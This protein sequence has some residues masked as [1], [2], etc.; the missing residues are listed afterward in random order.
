MSDRDGVKDL[1][2]DQLRKTGLTRET[3]W[4]ILGCIRTPMEEAITPDE[5][6]ANKRQSGVRV[7][8]LPEPDF[9]EAM[10]MI[11]LLTDQ[12]ADLQ[13]LREADAAALPEE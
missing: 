2:Y 13:A 12:V 3:C 8:G 11:R 9:L 1:D 10:E 6:E 4:A 7:P 5:L